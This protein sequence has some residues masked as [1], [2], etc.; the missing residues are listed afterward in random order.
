M[1]KK[2]YD[3]NYLL[4]YCNENKIFLFKNYGDLHLTRN[5]KI[6]GKCLTEMYDGTYNKTFLYIK[7]NW[8]FV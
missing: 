1:N 7:K 5:T 3:I 6:E 4:S 8:V 2:R